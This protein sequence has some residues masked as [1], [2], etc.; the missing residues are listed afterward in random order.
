LDSESLIERAI[1]EIQHEYAA[2][3]SRADRNVPV[4]IA[5]EPGQQFRVSGESLTLVGLD[6][7][8]R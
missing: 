8:F 5:F 4:W 1:I 6:S 2:N 7:H 3:A